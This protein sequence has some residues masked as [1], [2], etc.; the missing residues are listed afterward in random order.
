M[1]DRQG[2][3]RVQV[4]ERVVGDGRQVHDRIESGQVVGPDVAQVELQ[5]GH[6]VGVGAQGAARE[7]PGVEA[8]H[9]VPAVAQRGAQDPPQIAIVTGDAH[10]HRIHPRSPLGK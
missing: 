2:A 4:A 5:P 3:R 8:H 1:V 6:V 9:L 7:Q 10:F